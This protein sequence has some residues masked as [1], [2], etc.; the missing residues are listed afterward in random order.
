[1]ELEELQSA[2]AQMSRELEKQKEL[3][4][5]I[6]MDMTKEKYRA[7]FKTITN[8]EKAGTIVCLISALYIG[9]NIL[10]LDTWYLLLCGLFAILFS[11]LMPVLVLRSLKRIR[12]LNIIDLNYKD[13]LLQYTKA[14]NHLLRVQ[15]YGLYASFLY[16]M[17][18]LPAIAKIV[19][20]KNLFLEPSTLVWKLLIMAVFLAL[21]AQWGYGQYKRIT[22]SAEQLIKDLE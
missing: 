1:M 14:K 18:F 11:V 21:F 15:R 22:S 3:T 13:A 4:N 9:L 17:T 5:E 8:Y 19:N 6:I 2:W 7:K 10:K 20:D 16:L 12:K